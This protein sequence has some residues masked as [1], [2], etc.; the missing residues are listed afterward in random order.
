MES[1]APSVQ[2]VWHLVEPPEAVIG[3]FEGDPEYSLGRVVGAALLS[4]GRI[5]VG[6]GI[7]NEL[8]F[9]DSGGRHQLTVGG[10]GRGPGE[11][12]SLYAIDLLPGDRIVASEWPAG[13]SVWFDGYG[14][15]LKNTRIGPFWPGFAGR[16]LPDESFLVD[17]Y[18]RGS[19]GNEL[20]AWAARGDD[21]RFRPGGWLVR[22]PEPAADARD[23]LSSLAG[24][25]WFRR[26]KPRQ[27][28]VIRPMPFARNSHLTWSS[29]HIFLGENDRREIRV[30]G[31]DGALSRLLRW[32]GQDIA[33]TGADRSRFADEARTSFRQ[34]SRLPTLER[35]LSEVPFPATK[36]AFRALL[37]DSAEQLWVQTWSEH[38][39]EQDRWLVFANEGGWLATVE[40]PSGLELLDVGDDGVVLA[41][42]R[43]ELDVNYVRVYRLAK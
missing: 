4:D 16:Y 18:E 20:E 31:L 15:Y 35:W 26:G 43:D 40:V 5:V 17:V 8:R 28:L 29:S 30:L 24:E 21:D 41:L 7:S 12:R 19:Y 3:V 33:V 42:W 2:E 25:E 6:D 32:S 39:A 38:G 14:A 23:T 9:F 36:P 10:Q 22:L 13:S 27:D 1:S 34:Q 37:T 11:L